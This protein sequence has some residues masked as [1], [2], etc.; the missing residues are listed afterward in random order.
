MKKVTE[1]FGKLSYSPPNWL[2]TSCDKLKQKKD[3]FKTKIINNKLKYGIILGLSCFVFISGLTFLVYFLIRE[4]PYRVTISAD[5]PK[6]TKLKKDSKPYPL[7]LKFSD[8]VSPSKNVGREALSGIRIEPPIK[9]AWKWT[10][11]RLIVFTPKEDWAVGQEYTV[12]MDKELF[13]DTVELEKYKYNFK[14]APFEAKI[15]KME[16]YIDP[17]N[18]AVK[19]VISTIQFSHPVDTKALESNIKLTLKDSKKNFK[20]SYDEFKG[21]AYIQSDPIKISRKKT[22]MELEIGDDVHSSR[23]GPSLKDKLKRSVTVPGIYNYAYIN[24]VN[25]TLVRNEQYEL[26]QILLINASGDLVPSEIE[27]NIQVY[28]LP[29]DRPA[30]PGLK[31]IKKYDWYDTKEIS[32]QVLELSNRLK[33]TSI[34]IEEKF[35][36]LI[37][38]KYS[39]PPKKYIYVKIKKGV[40]FL[41]NFKLAKDFDRII[42]VNTFPKQIKILHDGAILSMGGEKKLSVLAHDVK[43]IRFKV[44]RVI[45]DQVNHLISQSR[46]HF[47]SPY[48][49]EH[50][51]T[52]ENI[53]E[54]Y[55]ELRKL[56][57]LKPGKMQYLA[58]D[59]TRYLTP[60]HG[61]RLKHGL[62]FFKAENWDPRK[63]KSNIDD[64]QN[65]E[66]NDAE[67]VNDEG[68]E[69]EP[70]N[71][72][73]DD[74]GNSGR[75]VSDRRLILVT[76]LGILVKKS[77]DGSGHVFVQSISTG[78]PVQN[79][80]VDVIGKNGLS[81]IS[82]STDSQGHCKL[83]SL[84]DYKFEK[85]PVA[86]VVRKSDDFSFLPYNR[87]DR[88]L[89]FSRFDIGG[90][91]GA[92]QPNRLHAYLFSD[93][94]IYRPG[95]TFHV[96]MIIKSSNWANN[97]SGIP[98]EAAIVN[99]SGLE[100]HKE[101]I[102]LSSSGFE[103]ISYKTNNTSPTGEYQIKTYIIKDK[104]RKNF[105]GSTSIRVE[106]FLPDRMKITTHF[107]DDK[108]DGWVSPKGLKGIV[109]LKNLFGTP[110]SG[111]RITAK[112]TLTPAITYFRKYKNYQFLDPDNERKGFQEDLGD[113]KTDEKGE[114]I[115]NLDLERFVKA[116]YHLRLFTEGFEKE[117]GRAVTSEKVVL[118]SSL[119][120]LVGYKPDGSL[121]YISK[122]S[123][124]NVEFIAINSQ[125]NKIS[126]NNLNARLVEIRY[127]SVLTKQ[128]N[129]VYKYQSVKKEIPI[130]ESKINISSK[131]LKYSLPTKNPGDYVIIILDKNNNK[132]SEIKFNI[133]G[134]GNLSRSLEKNTELQIRLNKSDYANGETI[135]L[136]I[137][138]PYVGTGL[139]TIERDDVYSYKWFKT[140]STASV[141]TIVIP[142]NLE[143]NGYVNISFIRSIDSKEIFMSPLSY[144]AVPFSVSK[145]KRTNNIQLIIPDIALPG[146]AFNI[147]YST[148]KPGKIVIF[149]VDEGILQ[150]AK[151]KTPNPLSHF[152]RKRALEVSTSQI[153]DLIL[154][155]FSIVRSLSAMGGD[156]S[157]A[158]IGANLNPFKRKQHKPVTFWSGILDSDSKIRDIN[159]DIPDYFNGTLRVM[160]VAVSD[161]SVGSDEKKA[162]IRDHFV[163]Q[164]NVPTFVSP[165]D[166]FELSVNITNNLKGSGK[167]AKIAFQVNTTD[168]FT[169][170]SKVPKIIEISEKKD[171]TIKLKVRTNKHPGS[172]TISFIASKGK[173]QSKI[174]EGLS[175]RPSTPYITTIESGFIKSDKLSIPI[176]RQM[177][178]Q[179]R[180]TKVSISY[181]P[182]GIAH[183]LIQYLEK[184]P[185]GCTEQLVS[186]AFP[187]LILRNRPE[188]G[189]SPK[190]SESALKEI[191]QVLRARQNA[192]GAFGFWAANSHVSDFQTIYAMHFLTEAKVKGYQVPQEMIEKG[193]SYLK[194][195]SIRPSD[196][197]ADLRTK[198]YAIYILTRNSA[199]MTN[200]IS[201]F[202]K[203]LET[204]SGWEKDLIGVYL[205]ATYKMMKQDNMADSIIRKSNL[206]DE[207]DAD[208]TNYYD[209]LIYKA[210]YIYII[211]MHFP[212]RLENITGDAIIS[213]VNPVIKG[214]YNTI[215][216]AYTV[217][218]LDALIK[219]LGVPVKDKVK[220]S[221]ILSANKTVNLNLPA[222]YFPS[223]TFSDKAKAI[224]IIND[225][226]KNLFYQI[227]QAGFDTTMP[228]STLKNKIEVYREYINEKGDILKETSLGQEIQVRIRVRSIDKKEHHNI[229]IVDLLPGGFEVSI[230]ASR[231]GEQMIS[232]WDKDAKAW[233]TPVGTME[234]TWKPEYVD[235]RE[236][237]ILMFGTVGPN[238]EEFVYRIRS[239]N[240]GNYKLPPLYG[241]SMYD[242]TIKSITPGGEISVKDK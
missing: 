223:M 170:L 81:I 180:K 95:D 89:N 88:K 158:E 107:S 35:S 61:S 228:S 239:V 214:S 1:L 116:S 212:D 45:P 100:I 219:N 126:I 152:F 117:S 130:S 10:S 230:D 9:G 171:I 17:K 19:R 83:P 30:I 47:K 66:P 93:R 74:N 136:Q 56:E 155:E 173:N 67:N 150:V 172:G 145:D 147:K 103:E 156:A 198:S 112:M 242:R 162:F 50:R 138:A 62:F 86:Y 218:A 146:K 179:Y 8:S 48:F 164:P 122:D 5:I 68:N 26:E 163:I 82:T 63:N 96:G 187:A 65:I 159:I 111:N 54:N 101:K 144:A 22:L 135:Q 80:V 140:K 174:T 23:G 51:F 161:D 105:L 236:D 15:S 90:L 207:K 220:V 166:E 139:I 49:G 77:T 197:L 7:K 222:G 69:N 213:L 184:F 241:E 39:A 204:H 186:Q 175:I 46:G 202:Q 73:D 29:K 71:G 132:L 196:T 53:V 225:E 217:L 34:P 27:K 177:Y 208:Y 157:Q 165:N 11:D 94:G 3:S 143:G 6:A 113:Q 178:P 131:G 110:A 206:K 13:T 183:G 52:D 237:R 106:E 102:K 43:N 109:N 24:S 121:S 38:F 79:A 238:V 191:V 148:K 151:Y 37:S 193:L 92:S 234:S 142:Q 64:D 188:F 124:R 115:F 167:N 182:L 72:E 70:G 85:T 120:Y 232:G 118:V 127:V 42:K 57:K 190:R 160:A 216:S 189:Y 16:F 154:P 98:L 128:S 133:M 221:E 125:L 240:K 76:D 114:A 87:H 31:A 78:N 194:T 235:I 168:H 192:E 134:H 210:Q 129:G 224:K 141:Q 104:K 99:P 205:A 137:R 215:S 14:S 91:Y 153:L 233:K 176:K 185:Y 97:I 201:S 169:L 25:Q 55:Y 58:F 28:V 123:Q 108:D 75:D 149:A 36:R 12:Y 200:A 84:N 119:P 229:A 33:L 195:I 60:K 203:E 211:S 227:T 231:S 40:N 4:K 20:V 59:F 21:E 226:D 2:K 18:P 209:N 199:L 41:G 181:L 44:G 32:P